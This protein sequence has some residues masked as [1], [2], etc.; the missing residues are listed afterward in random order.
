MSL[1][2]I[3]DILVPRVGVAMG[4]VGDGLCNEPRRSFDF[5]A[6]VYAEQ[7][8]KEMSIFSIRTLTVMLHS[9]V[10]CACT[11]S[12]PY[13]SHSYI[14]DLNIITIYECVNFW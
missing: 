7:V 11:A 13:Y 14:L 8:N 10:F 5:T 4:C 1:Y 2:N 6:H 12:K 3:V 9:N